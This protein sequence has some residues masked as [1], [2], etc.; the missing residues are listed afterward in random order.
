MRLCFK[1]DLSGLEVGL[2]ELE[3]DLSFVR[4]E[5]GF[6]VEVERVSENRLQ[7]QLKEKKGRIRL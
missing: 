4:D 7:V 2:R 6:P 1:G 3:T 5:E